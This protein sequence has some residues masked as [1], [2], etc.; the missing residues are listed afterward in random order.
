MRRVVL[1]ALG[2]AVC[3][4]AQVARTPGRVSSTPGRIPGIGSGNIVYPGTPG[5]SSPGRI[6]SPGLPNPTP[7][8]PRPGNVLT[9]GTPPPRNPVPPA[10][11]QVGQPN[12]RRPRPRGRTARPVVYV[13]FYYPVYGYDAPNVIYVPPGR[14]SYSSSSHVITVGQ[15][16]GREISARD[17]PS[18]DS[19]P[20]DPE[21][22]TAEE[23]NEDEYYLIALEGGLIYAAS[24]Y[25]VNGRT[26]EFV[27][28]QGER[29]VVSLAELD[30][31]F[32]RKLN[33][34]RGVEISIE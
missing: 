6:T 8:P 4:G 1:L 20:P 18:T 30:L 19:A 16:D 9:P 33:S 24:S 11:V 23:A 25:T 22:P 15:D 7:A 12:G 10:S 28:L 29:Y 34:D 2:F 3:A 14:R 31:T 27:T 26:L 21:P 17:L 32:T 13:P 5:R